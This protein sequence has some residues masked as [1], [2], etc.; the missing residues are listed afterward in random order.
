VGRGWRRGR[1]GGGDQGAAAARG[2][3]RDLGFRGER[4]VLGGGA[5]WREGVV[6][7]CMKPEGFFAKQ[8]NPRLRDTSAVGRGEESKAGQVLIYPIQ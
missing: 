1:R 7:K 5:G 2:R 4:G 6:A 8:P 3:E